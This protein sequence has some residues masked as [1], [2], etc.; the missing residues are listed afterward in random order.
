MAGTAT[1]S[2]ERDG[3]LL[4]VVIDNAGRRNALTTSMWGQLAEVTRKADAEPD[5][6][7]VLYRG[8]GEDAFCAGADISEF[9]QKRQSP[10]DAVA[11]DR[12]TFSAFDA[13][14]GCAKPTVAMIHGFCMG[15]GLFVALCCDIRIAETGA[16]FAVP[17]AKLGLGL[18]P[19]LLPRLIGAVG[20]ARAKELIFTGRRV[21]HAEALAMGLV[22]RVVPKADFEA[23][24]QTLVDEIAANAPLTLKAAKQGI[25]AI[26]LTGGVDYA[27]LDAFTRACF[28]SA[29]YTEG[30]KAFAEKRKPEFQGR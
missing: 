8:A 13:I 29:D 23:A 11:Y 30:R 10:D 26:G 28:D 3:G 17:A 18:N 21:D 12:V 27:P 16:S 15:G 6:R 24:T 4:R 19:R 14:A 20:P 2:T 22:S 1:I 5:I 7:V 9:D 25:N